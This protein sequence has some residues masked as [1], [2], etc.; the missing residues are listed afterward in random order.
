VGV[1]VVEGGGLWCLVR[2]QLLVEDPVTL[3][4]YVVLGGVSLVRALPFCWVALEG[5][6]RPGNFSDALLMDRLAPSW[7]GLFPD[8]DRIDLRPNLARVACK[9]GVKQ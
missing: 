2:L 9:L 5:C 1:V 6:P 7:K 3:G 8:V 4:M